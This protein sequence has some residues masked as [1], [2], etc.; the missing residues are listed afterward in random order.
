MIKNGIKKLQ[1]QITKL[2][3]MITKIRLTRQ[4]TFQKNS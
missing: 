1:I 4:Q 2:D 3:S